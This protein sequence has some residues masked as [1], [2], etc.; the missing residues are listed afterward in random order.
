MA[1]KVRGPKSCFGPVFLNGYFHLAT[2]Q[3]LGVLTP[4]PTPLPAQTTW[5]H[6]EAYA[7]SLPHPPSTEH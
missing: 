3:T 5:S 2:L 6:T 4:L 7:A 1:D